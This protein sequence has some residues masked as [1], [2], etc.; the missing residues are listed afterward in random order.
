MNTSEILIVTGK[1]GS[2]KTTLLQQAFAGKENV[3]GILTP[4]RNGKRM[5]FDLAL[6]EYFPM[7]AGEN[8]SDILLVGKFRF[9]KQSF[10]KAT[11]IL[12]KALNESNGTVILDEV[13]PLELRGEGF[14]EMVRRMV[15]NEN[16]D[17]TKLLVIREHLFE[18]VL[19]TFSITKYR[20]ITP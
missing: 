13:G 3:F 17:L 10:D 12:T 20:I 19:K 18:E 11:T 15:A 7:E 8:E 16:K 2:G 14:C 4:V 1:I 5:F 6:N 9:S